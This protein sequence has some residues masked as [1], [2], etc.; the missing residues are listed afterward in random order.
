VLLEEHGGLP[1]EE[2]GYPPKI[3]DPSR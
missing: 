1:G 3:E 2:R